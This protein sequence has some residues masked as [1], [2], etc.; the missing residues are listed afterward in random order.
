MTMLAC[1]S[2]GLAAL[3]AG[4]ALVLAPLPALA[5]DDALPEGFQSTP[6]LQTT[7]TRDGDALAYPQG[8]AQITAVIAEMEPDGRTS[9]H[10]HP[11]PT[12]VYVLEGT[13]ELRTEGGDPTRY[14]AGGSYIEALDRDHQL[15]N[16]GDETARL[17][18]VFAGAE[19]T[20][21]TVAATQ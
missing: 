6:L 10:Q 14:E 8:Q 7:Q 9:L 12:F 1:K 17:L 16:V 2:Y 11:V 3:V 15:F 4:A 19:G 13:V 20:P 21:T 5:S 18:V